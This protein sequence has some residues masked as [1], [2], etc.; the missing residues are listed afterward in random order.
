VPNG[1]AQGGTV[2]LAVKMVKVKVR[3]MVTSVRVG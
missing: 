3:A 1:K 2:D